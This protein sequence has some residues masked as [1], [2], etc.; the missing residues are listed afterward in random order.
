[1]T[2]QPKPLFK[3]IRLGISG[4]I[5]LH[6]MA[7][8]LPPIWFQSRPS[9]IVETLIAPVEAYGQF[10][11][12]DR[13]YAFF[14]PDPGPS[15]L[16]QAAIKD[17]SGERVEEMYPDRE[18]QRPRLLYHRHFMLTEFLEESYQPPGP[19]AE[20]ANLD[21]EAA[22]E[23]I[24]L[25]ARYEHIRTSYVDHLKQ[26]HPGKEVEG[27]RRIEHLIP[28]ITEF[29]EDPIELTDQRLYR[30]LLDLPIRFDNDEDSLVAPARPPETIPPPS[31]EAEATEDDEASSSE[32]KNTVPHAG[33]RGAIEDAAQQS[34]SEDDSDASEPSDQAVEDSGQQDS[35]EQVE[36]R[37]EEGEASD[38]ASD[39]DQEETS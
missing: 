29:R 20:L 33:A 14:A 4:L 8:I 30:V 2:A 36:K 23:W 28:G 31:G 35:S 1:M 26:V 27:I 21:R 7:V 22:E 12:I 16:I 3:F 5:V 13:G 9:P 18:R 37:A 39:E 17:G 38:D 15:H 34:E 24:Q 25:R 19:P 6:L 32:S 10:L 11:Y